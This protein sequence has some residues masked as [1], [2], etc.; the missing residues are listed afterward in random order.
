MQNFCHLSLVVCRSHHITD[1]QGPGPKDPAAAAAAAARREAMR[2]ALSN[3]NPDVA[4]TSAPSSNSSKSNDSHN[5]QNKP[6]AATSSRSAP[7]TSAYTTPPRPALHPHAHAHAQHSGP[8]R[9]ESPSIP[10]GGIDT[11][12]ARAAAQYRAQAA[13]LE[14]DVPGAEMGMSIQGFS[15]ARGIKR[16]SEEM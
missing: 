15:S 6:A 4:A 12:A 7:A 11:A 2:S 8:I 9:A 1:A 10:Q 16:V 13:K 5:A 3:G 14:L